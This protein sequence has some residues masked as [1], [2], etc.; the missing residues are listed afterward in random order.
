M[1]QTGSRIHM[2]KCLF[3]HGNKLSATIK[4]EDFLDYL[5]NTYFFLRK[6]AEIK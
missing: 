3:I 1:V 4:D 6:L 5:S 2:I